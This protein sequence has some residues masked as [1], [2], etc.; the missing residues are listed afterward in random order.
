[1][2]SV[3]GTGNFSKRI[4]VVMMSCWSRSG[5]DLKPL[6][7]LACNSGLQPLFAR[8]MVERVVEMKKAL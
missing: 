1:M 7:V 5:G 2:S 6:D 3:L 4:S 8:K